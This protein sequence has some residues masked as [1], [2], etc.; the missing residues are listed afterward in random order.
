MSR[1]PVIACPHCARLHERLPVQ[2]GAMA[3]CSQC[4]H[5]LYRQSR[6]SLYSWIALVLTALVIFCIANYFPIVSLRAQGLTIQATLVGALTLTWQQG[7]A[8]LAIMTGLFS[9]VFPLG[10]IL[11]LLWALMALVT[12]RIP[13]D[14]HYGLRVLRVITSWSMVPVFQLGLLVAIV[15]LA[16]MAVI[17]TGP[18][19]WAFAAL[20]VVMTALGR[21]S[22]TRIW[23]HAEDAGLVPVSGALLRDGDTPVDCLECGYV[24]PVIPRALRQSCARCSAPLHLRKPNDEG[25]AWAFVIAAGLLYIPANVLPVMYVRLPTGVTSHT[26]LGGVVELWRLG[27]WD[28]SI[29]VFIASVVVPMTKLFVLAALLVRRPHWRG[30]SIQR[31]RTRLYEMVEFVGQ[32]SMLDV[33][34]VILLSSMGNFPGISQITAGAGAVSFGVV[35]VLTMFAAMSYDPRRGWDRLPLHGGSTVSGSGTLSALGGNLAREVHKENA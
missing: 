22:A 31:Q 18:G 11:F 14:F 27:S 30:V 9:F 19:L 12:R 8:F 23:R 17:S 13:W 7:H 2:A 24:Q 21:V 28:L 35:V 33:F 29:I 32:W 5:T 34:V 6:L 3:S 20:T 16:D 1:W 10:Q 26:I 25:R 4:G 15:K